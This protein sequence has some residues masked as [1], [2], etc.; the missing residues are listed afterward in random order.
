MISHPAF[1][2]LLW[3]FLQLSS[4]VADGKDV[5]IGATTGVD[6]LL[7]TSRVFEANMLSHKIGQESGD[8]WSVT[9]SRPAA[10]Y[11]SFGPY[12]DNLEPGNL[13]VTFNVMADL[14]ITVNFLLATLDVF[15]VTAGVVL[16]KRDL[17]RGSFMVA[18]E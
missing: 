7:L 17:Y 15:D 6:N 3:I 8:A 13:T 11:M 18:D 5:S 9:A 14:T 16:A 10:D 4:V 2:Q 12:V 1:G